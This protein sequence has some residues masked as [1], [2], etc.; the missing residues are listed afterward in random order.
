MASLEEKLRFK[1]E[2]FRLTKQTSSIPVDDPYWGIFWNCPTCAGDIFDL[3]SATDIRSIRETNKS[4]FITLIRVIALQLVYQSDK[5]T[6]LDENTAL[7]NCIRVLTKFLPSLYEDPSLE[8]VEKSLFWS[9]DT[10]YNRDATPGSQC[11]DVATVATELSSS[12]V[13]SN[14]LHDS[15][16]TSAQVEFQSTQNHIEQASIKA[17]VGSPDY[18]TVPLGAKL[19]FTLVQLLFTENFCIE[20]QSPVRSKGIKPIV[21]FSI[22][23]PG[24]GFNGPFKPPNTFIDS[25]RYETMKLLITLCSRCLYIPSSELVAQGSRFLTVLVTALPRLQI[26][27]LL[28]SLLNLTARASRDSKESG[29]E[30]NNSQLNNLRTLN[31]T[32]ALHLLTLMFV[33]PLPKNNLQF[34]Q[35]L[36]IYDSTPINLV[37]YYMGRLHKES[38][39]V[40]LKVSLFG[41]LKAPLIEMSKLENSTSLTAMIKAKTYTIQPSLW[42]TEVLILVWELYQSNKKFSHLISAKHSVELSLILLF[43]INY[44]R[45]D[46][47]HRNQVRICSY[48]FLYL[49]NDEQIAFNLLKPFNGS[50]YSSLPQ[51]F[52]TPTTPVTYRDFFIV[53]ICTMLLDDEPG[54]LTSTLIEMLYNLIPITRADFLSSHTDEITSFRKRPF[55]NSATVCEQNG[56]ISHSASANL[57][58]VVVKLSRPQYLASNSLHSDLLGLVLR[59]IAHYLGKNFHGVASA[60]LGDVAAMAYTLTKNYKIFNEVKKVIESVGHISDLDTKKTLSVHSTESNVYDLESIDPSED[61]SEDEEAKYNLMNLKMPVGMSTKVKGKQ[62]LDAPLKKT[63][64]GTKALKSILNFT[65]YLN[66]EHT[67]L[68]HITDFNTVV[69]SIAN[70]SIKQQSWEKLVHRE[71][72]P[73]YRPWSCLKFVWNNASLGWYESVLW[74][75]I[76]NSNEIIHRNKALLDLNNSISAI[77]KATSDWSF[78]MWKSPRPESTYPSIQKQVERASKSLVDTGTWNG[79]YVKTFRIKGSGQHSKLL[80]HRGAINTM[81][82][83]LVKKITDF[84]IS[85]PSANGPTS[86]Q[87]QNPHPEGH[88]NLAETVQLKVTPR[89]YIHRKDSTLSTLSTL[90]T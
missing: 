23:E 85:S 15:S 9:L 51:S 60:D 19:V 30:M 67:E 38:E 49:T 54:I 13:L 18:S 57:M 80:N 69:I 77:T 70:T 52:K 56:Q 55:N 71:F 64:T 26:L 75:L 47:H 66:K 62:P 33:Y 12:S 34:L 41:I 20:P 53:R 2:V 63:W 17:N 58:H 32:E 79:T 81:T 4:N 43:Y 10:L 86:H 31:V 76:Y 59:A 88:P 1:S 87:L 73:S 7:L 28:S 39:L 5:V 11:S 68:L 50:I 48:F 36:R 25:N 46:E 6:S 89:N 90:S 24:I 27:T 8:E 22:W 61:E 82:D 14:Q 65:N 44:Y 84:R 83:S 21:D 35:E 78:G 16:S 37:R 3:L 74:G 29:L 40:F 42:C 72:L 45:K